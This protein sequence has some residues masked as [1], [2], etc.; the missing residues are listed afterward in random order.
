MSKRPTQEDVAR[1][2]GVSRATVSYVINNRTDGNVRISEE[3]RCRVLDAVKELGYRPNVLARSLRQGQTHTI[4]MIVPDNTNP[5]FA[6]VARGVEDTSF[7]QGYSV[8]LCN[9]DS[10]LDKEL[11]YT[12]VLTEKRVDGILFVAVGMSAERICVL[13]ER[14]MPVVVVDRDIPDVAVDSVM[15][16][17]ERGGRLATHHL[18]ELGHRRIG[19][20]AGPSDVTPSA[21]RGT[22][23]RQ[24][25]REAVLPVEE[26]LIMKGD[27][28]YE[29]GY[30]AAR[31]LLSMDDPPTA[32][33][34]CN[35]LM[36]IGAI[37]AAVEL[38]RQVPADLS[39]VGFDDVPLASFANPAL[40]TVVQP[41]HEIGV[42]AATMLLERMQDPDRPPRRKM[43]DTELVIRKSTAPAEPRPPIR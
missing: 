31:Q 20:I 36:A 18:I 5:F 19:C 7:E 25:L 40:T 33:F 15:T 24:A 4:G 6:E 28:Q 37:S 8:I 23:Y 41:K 21:E 14:H 26:E 2:A 35:D 9:S 32:I 11:L 17:N 29:S 39:V 1:L 42:V 38:G 43:L 34:A 13:Q 27:F 10:D 30:Q 3:T 22:G 16:A 12:N